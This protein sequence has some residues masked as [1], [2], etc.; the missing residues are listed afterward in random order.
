MENIIYKKI[1]DHHSGS[2]NFNALSVGLEFSWYVSSDRSRY[3][4]NNLHNGSWDLTVNEFNKKTGLNYQYAWK[5]PNSE[6]DISALLKSGCVIAISGTPKKNSIIEVGDV[7]KV[8]TETNLNGWLLVGTE[9][10]CKKA[11]DSIN[12]IITKN[13]TNPLERNQ[14]WGTT[15]ETLNSAIRRGEVEIIKN[16]TDQITNTEHITKKR[17][18]MQNISELG[19]KEAIL[20][21]K[22]SEAQK[23]QWKMGLIDL[24]G[25]LTSAGEIYVKEFVEEKFKEEA[26]AAVVNTVTAVYAEAKK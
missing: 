7:V 2:T 26:L 9:L 22:L 13:L 6:P 1:A 11:A 18:K 14:V 10:T 19:T 5:I 24:T 15:V 16:N 12:F 17:K 23:E 20:Y 8:I 4:M 3:I 21:S 25:K